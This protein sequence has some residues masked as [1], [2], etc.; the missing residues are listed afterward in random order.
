MGFGGLANATNT[1]F[2]LG[3]SRWSAA[4]TTSVATGV[5]AIATGPGPKHMSVYARV[6]AFM[7]CVHVCPVTAQDRN[8]ACSEQRPPAFWDAD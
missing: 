4:T 8:H 3:D 7:L 1:D 6:H 2:V 5:V